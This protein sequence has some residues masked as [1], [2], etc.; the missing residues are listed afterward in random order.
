[1]SLEDLYVLDAA[2]PTVRLQIRKGVVE[3]RGP[4]GTE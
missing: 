4:R 1:M 3:H 2:V